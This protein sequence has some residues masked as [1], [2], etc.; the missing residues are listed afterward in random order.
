MLLIKNYFSDEGAEAVDKNTFSFYEIWRFSAHKTEK[1]RS[2]S[3]PFLTLLLL[4]L[5]HYHPHKNY[6]FTSFITLLLLQ[7]QKFRLRFPYL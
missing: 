1:S 5:K 7:K 2:L 6:L 4:P 3:K